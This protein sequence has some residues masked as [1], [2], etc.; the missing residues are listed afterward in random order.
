MREATIQVLLNKDRVTIRM[1]WCMRSA[2]SRYNRL[3]RRVGLPVF[4]RE[5]AAREIPERIESH[6]L[7]MKAFPDLNFVAGV[8][9][10]INWRLS[11]AL[12]VFKNG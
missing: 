2:F 10:Q 11:Q 7:F 4:R 3:C 12:E 8:L 1:P 9:I 6:S 5:F